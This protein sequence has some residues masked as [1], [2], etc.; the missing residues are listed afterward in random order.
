M[1]CHHK[2]T[3]TRKPWPLF[4]RNW[5]AQIWYLLCNCE[6]ILKGSSRRLDWSSIWMS[7][8]K[9]SRISLIIEVTDIS[10]LAHDEQMKN[11]WATE[12]L[13]A[14]RRY[15]HRTVFVLPQATRNFSV[16]QKRN[17]FRTPK[18]QQIASG[19]W[20]VCRYTSLQAKVPKNSLISDLW[21]EYWETLAE[22]N[23]DWK[24][25]VICCPDDPA[26]RPHGA[27]LALAFQLIRGI[28]NTYDCENRTKYDHD[29]ETKYDH[30][31]GEKNDHEIRKMQADVMKMLNQNE[32]GEVFHYASSSLLAYQTIL[33]SLVWIALTASS[34]LRS[35]C[36]LIGWSLHWIA[37]SGKTLPRHGSCKLCDR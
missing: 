7:N 5:E 8:S 16:L 14:L 26:G 28:V 29:K 31:K 13:S 32:P 11:A 22:D 18:N 4:N 1:L 19:V 10:N 23:T 15:K 34:W 21:H 24:G 9:I 6:H 3:S 35:H 2:N 36:L 37:S 12:Q 17:F 20:S 25:S 33:P 30:D 27:Q